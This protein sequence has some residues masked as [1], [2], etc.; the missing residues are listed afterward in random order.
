M[1]K[2]HTSS[3]LL[4][5]LVVLGTA[6][7]LGLSGC[8]SSDGE[9]TESATGSAASSSASAAASAESSAAN[10]ENAVS[11]PLT[12]PTAFGD[13]TIKERPNRVATLGFGDEAL[14]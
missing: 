10:S 7:A 13:V 8:S 14:L 2:T 1:T 11:Y 6:T 5:S 3:R 12:L 9:N 4:R